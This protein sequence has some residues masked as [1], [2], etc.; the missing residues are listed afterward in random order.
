MRIFPGYWNNNQTGK[1]IHNN[2]EKRVL[3][4]PQPKPDVAGPHQLL[5]YCAT[6]DIAIQPKYAERLL[7]SKAVV[8]RNCRECPLPE[9]FD[10]YNSTPA[11]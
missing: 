4:Q 11:K 5:V 1:K 6:P 3:Q 2:I 9:R 10:N 8:Q 7:L